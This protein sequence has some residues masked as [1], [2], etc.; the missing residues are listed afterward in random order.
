MQKKLRASRKE[1]ATF[2]V[3]ISMGFEL[4]LQENILE[5]RNDE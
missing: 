5:D 3:K 2:F 4:L 1:I